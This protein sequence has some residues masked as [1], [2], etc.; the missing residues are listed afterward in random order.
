MSNFLIYQASAGSG[1][2]YTL[3]KEYL[4]LAFINPKS[5]RHILAITFTNKATE[6]MKTRV[7]NKLVELSEGKDDKYAEEI[8]KEIEAE[9]KF[10]KN[11]DVRKESTAL[12]TSI[13]HDYSAFTISTIDSFSVRVMRSFAKE[14]KIPFG[15]DLELESA[16]VLDEITDK[17]LDRA[18]S[19]TELTTYLEDYIISNLDDNR[20]WHIEDIIKNAG[21]EIFSERYWNI[22]FEKHGAVFTEDRASVK[23]VIESI[24]GI[25]YSFENHLK[26]LG[27]KAVALIKKHNFTV[28]DFVQGNRGVWSTLTRKII[29]DK[30]YELKTYQHNAR[31][32][33]DKFFNS[34]NTSRASDYAQASELYEI[35]IE[36]YDQIAVNVR[37]Y[38]TAD[39]ICRNIYLS[40]VFADLLE[41]LNKY[42]LENRVL[43]ASDLNLMLRS[44]IS[45]DISPF[46]YEKIGSNFHNYLIDEFQDTSDFQWKNFLPLII[47]ALSERHTAMIVGD[48]KQSV[49]RWRGGDMQLLLHKVRE[50][51]AGFNDIIKTETLKTNRRSQ[52]YIVEFNNKFFSLLL[53]LAGGGIEESRCKS[54]INPSYD[55]ESV[56]QEI[57]ESK[58]GG[59][60]NVTIID[61]KDEEGNKEMQIAGA[62]AIQY[63]NEIIADGY[64]ESDILVLVRTAKE[65]IAISEL[66]SADGKDVISS[67]SLLLN[68]SP[69]IKLII[70]VL[71]YISDNKNNLAKTELL[72]LYLEYIKKS[73]TPSGEIFTDWQKKQENLFEDLL[74][75]N[76]FHE[77]DT[78]KLKPLLYD[79][80]LYELIEQLLGVFGLNENPDPYIL[81]F[82]ESAFTYTKKYD[83]DINAFLEWW[84]DN[85]ENLSITIPEGINAIRVMTIHKAKGLQSRVVV[86]PYANWT[87]NPDSNKNFIWASSDVEPF[88]S[89]DSFYV[90]TVQSLS[91]TYFSEPYMDELALTRIDNMNLLYVAF[92]RAEERLYIVSP[93]RNGISAYSMINGIINSEPAFSDKFS[94]GVFEYGDK[95]KAGDV[96]GRKEYEKTIGTE[97][98]GKFN[99]NEWYRKTV[100]RPSY[101]KLKIFEEGSFRLQT[102]KGNIIH[103]ILS[104]LRYADELDSALTQI[105][106]EGLISSEDTQEFKTLIMNILSDKT[107]GDWY[108][109]GWEV[110]NESEILLKDGSIFRPDRVITKKDEVIII[111]YKTGIEKDEYKNQLNGYADIIKQMKY[112]QII[113][114][115]LYLSESKGGIT[116]IVKV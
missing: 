55:K 108:S 79:L 40:G 64:S 95:I 68:N 80:S 85:Y 6:E 106:A 9:Y 28:D 100:I 71:K 52:R 116:N 4:K 24:T 23:S 83:S 77:N 44:L 105:L 16:V 57:L 7:V 103:E 66:I 74:P 3:V 39:E 76:F 54:L 102:K 19:D 5:Y 75:D 63:I 41:E 49:Y 73:R 58:P 97:T 14:L 87:M 22:K 45:K 81:K 70:S 8:K 99:S 46:I 33:I 115:L 27:E 48:V 61:S 94:G 104:Y 78:T 15:F 26:L 62:K 1:K 84:T 32:S 92:T 29:Y 112:S 93:K 31:T 35:F 36:A 101:K 67:E 20:S 89:A 113:K 65:G 60:V 69:G 2:T 88:N 59:Y 86:I 43:L 13:L 18:G 10:I 11:L 17:L 30:N 96:I 51:L 50:D 38:Y 56:N 25:K 110:R 90:R 114:Y 12:I 21:K 42:R 82:Q 53:E 109:R 91:I 34:K 111:D 47:N 98:L 107:A 37:A 72:Y